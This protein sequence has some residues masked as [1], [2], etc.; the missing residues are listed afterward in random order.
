MVDVVA[1]LVSAI[2]TFERGEFRGCQ[3]D[4]LRE[5]SACHP[6]PLVCDTIARSR[7]RMTVLRREDMQSR[8]ASWD[9]SP[10]RIASSLILTIV[11]LIIRRLRGPS[12]TASCFQLLIIHPLLARLTAPALRPVAA[13]PTRSPRARAR[14]PRRSSV[15]AYAPPP[16]CGTV[17]T[18]AVAPCPQSQSPATVVLCGAG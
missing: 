1:H 14:S 10:Y 17:D 16:V 11:P 18:T 6:F 8:V 7:A 3:L 13:R 2:A 5:G 12:R 15:L 4:S 9:G